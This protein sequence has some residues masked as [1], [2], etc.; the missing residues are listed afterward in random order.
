MSLVHVALSV[1]RGVHCVERDDQALT[2]RFPLFA[3]LA[4]RP[5]L[6]QDP[7]RRHDRQARPFRLVARAFIPPSSPISTPNPGSSPGSPRAPLL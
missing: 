3:A 5:R 2:V 7:L 6:D 4:G 1:M